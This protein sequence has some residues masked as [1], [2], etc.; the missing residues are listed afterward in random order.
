MLAS[1]G[2]SMMGVSE[3]DEESPTVKLSRKRSSLATRTSMKGSTKVDQLSKSFAY[4]SCYQSES[5]HVI[6][7]REGLESAR[8]TIE[9]NHDNVYSGAFI[10]KAAPDLG[11]YRDRPAL[12]ALHSLHE[13]RFDNINRDPTKTKV[14]G[15]LNFSRIKP[16][17]LKETLLP[18]RPYQVDYRN[19]AR[20]KDYVMQRQG[21]GSVEMHKHKLKKLESRGTRNSACIP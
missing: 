13:K 16:R 17:D 2:N 6:R 19:S 14:I 1:A 8:F 20:G 15:T 7:G 10:V 9:P 21:L 11:R 18:E 4:D 5:Y 12:N 3:V